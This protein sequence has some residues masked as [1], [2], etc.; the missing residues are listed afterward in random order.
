MLPIGVA[1]GV[2]HGLLGMPEDFGTA[3]RRLNAGLVRASV[4]WGQVEPEPGR[5]DWTV[6]DRL[7]DQV[8]GWGRLWL[9][10]CSSSLWA[11]RTSTG[12]LPSSPPRDPAAYVRFLTALIEHCAGRVDFWQCESEPSTGLLWAGSAAEYAEL[13]AAFADTVRSV[14]PDPPSSRLKPGSP[15]VVGTPRQGEIVLGGL[16]PDGLDSAPGSE[17]WRF[18][19]LV[20][21]T[22]GECFDLVDVHLY[23]DPSRIPARL[24]AVRD[25][26]ERNDCSRPLVVGEYGGPTIFGFSEAQR[27]VQQVLAEPTGG[28]EALGE[29]DRRMPELPTEL[30]QFLEGCPAEVAARRDRIACR[31]LVT[32]NL[33]ALAEGAVGTVYARLAP[34]LLDQS[35]LD[36]LLGLALAKLPLLEFTDGHL[37]E[38][39]P[40]AASFRMLAAA[41]AGATAVRRISLGDRPEVNAF[42]VTFTDGPERALQVLWRD[43]SDPFTGDSDLHEAYEWHWV[44]PEL[45]AADAFAQPVPLPAWASGRLAVPLSATPVLLSTEPLATV[46]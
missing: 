5:F 30:Q 16:G 19:D 25:L 40:A 14:R 46:A 26:L 36:H 17:A 37:V 27:V 3:A 23:D 38:A 24:A 39:Q 20:S 7:L 10:V 43:D 44:H 11:T 1:G 35:D 15:S 9:T 28:E 22:A 21:R 2:S 13:L 33:L 42:D 8:A 31:E 12:S 45:H 29:L 4:H 18:L 32:R 34:E 41:L 6:V